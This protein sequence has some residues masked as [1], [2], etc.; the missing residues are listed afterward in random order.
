M[1]KTR[2]THQP[3]QRADPDL[4]EGWVLAS[5]GDGLLVDVQPGFACGTHNRDGQG[6]GHL[7]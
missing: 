1:S 6:I 7:R 3:P 4:P 5:L 2:P